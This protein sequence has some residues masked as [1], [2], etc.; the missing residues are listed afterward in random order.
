MPVASDAIVINTGPLIALAA[1][2]SRHGIWL[3][4]ALVR[5]VLA[6]ALE[7]AAPRGGDRS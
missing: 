1:W 6:E 7:P 3:G 2:R 4:D 5:R